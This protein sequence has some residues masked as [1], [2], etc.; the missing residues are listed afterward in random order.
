MKADYNINIKGTTRNIKPGAKLPGPSPKLI[1]SRTF[2]PQADILT[3]H[4]FT[5]LE[6]YNIL[7]SELMSVFLLS[8][9]ILFSSSVEA[10]KFSRLARRLSL[11]HAIIMLDSTFTNIHNNYPYKTRG[12]VIMLP[13]VTRPDS[14]LFSL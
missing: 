14:F 3:V 13:N 4:E 12:L 8:I 7:S 11:L 2:E 1:A 9:S 5:A 10:I 6:S